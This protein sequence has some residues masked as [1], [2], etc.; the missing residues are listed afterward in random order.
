MF[1]SVA[2]FSILLNVFCLIASMDLFLG[3]AW[4]RWTM[5]VPC[6]FELL[7]AY[8]FFVLKRPRSTL[9]QIAFILALASLA[10]IFSP[11]HEPFS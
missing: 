7:S 11:R 8:A 6:F 10:L 2:A 5:C 3:V 1:L 9:D 4:A